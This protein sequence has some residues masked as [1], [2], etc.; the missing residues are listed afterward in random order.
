[1][2]PDLQPL[3]YAKLWKFTAQA[4]SSRVLRVWDLSGQIYQLTWG[5]H[6]YL[7]AKVKFSEF[8]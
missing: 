8:G 2:N 5:Q 3:L 7:S 1:M 4:A 6:V